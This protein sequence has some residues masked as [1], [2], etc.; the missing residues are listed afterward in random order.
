MPGSN[1]GGFLEV[2]RMM[3][4]LDGNEAHEFG[5]RVIVVEREFGE[6]ADR[7]LGTEGLEAEGGFAIANPRIL[8][9]ETSDV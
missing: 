9:L 6:A 3:N 1:D 2:L 8:V 4:V 7:L 5:V